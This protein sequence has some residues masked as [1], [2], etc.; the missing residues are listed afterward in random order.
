MSLNE[1]NDVA[2]RLGEKH[3]ASRYFSIQARDD[4]DD[5]EKDGDEE[6]EAKDVEDFSVQQ[7]NGKWSEQWACERCHRRHD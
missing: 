7:R 1:A 2:K 6:G 3:Q 4:D 5:E